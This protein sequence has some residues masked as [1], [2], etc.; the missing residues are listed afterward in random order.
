[1]LLSLQKCLLSWNELKK[2]V[3][4]FLSHVLFLE[5]VNSS[6]PLDYFKV[7]PPKRSEGDP[8]EVRVSDLSHHRRSKMSSNT[9]L[10][11]PPLFK[12]GF[13]PSEFYNAVKYTVPI[14]DGC[15]LVHV[16][17]HLDLTG[18]NQVDYLTQMLTLRIW[19]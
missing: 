16:T 6:S 7:L 8:A 15:T 1:M 17:L 10:Q 9:V 5:N 2:F 18:Q 4:T 19:A 14:V 3:E 12:V 11:I 13:M